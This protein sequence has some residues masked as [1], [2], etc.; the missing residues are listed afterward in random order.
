[1]ILWPVGHAFPSDAVRQV[2]FDVVGLP[3]A[4]SVQSAYEQHEVGSANE[5]GVDTEDG[6][7]AA[8]D[9]LG[10]AHEAGLGDDVREVGADT[11]GDMGRERQVAAED[12]M[13]TN[14]D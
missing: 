8:S 11:A 2:P 12:G 13:E 7:V 4:A 6:W 14:F 3:L 10:A 5:A 9:E 1:M